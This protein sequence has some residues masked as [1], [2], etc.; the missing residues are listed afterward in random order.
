MRTIIKHALL[1]TA[2]QA[3][4]NGLGLIPQMGWNTWN[5]FACDINEDMFKQMADRMV[6][7]GFKEAGYNY[8]NLDDCW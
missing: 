3:L 5:T 4:D 8:V 2:A 7:M 6:D 1:A